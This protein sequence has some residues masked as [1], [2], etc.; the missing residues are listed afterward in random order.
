[1]NYIST[2]L[3]QRMSGYQRAPF[4]GVFRHVLFVE[5]IF[6][7]NRCGRA[8]TPS[9]VFHVSFAKMLCLCSPITG[10]RQ[11][12]LPGNIQGAQ[13]NLDFRSTRDTFLVH[14]CLKHCMGY[15]YTRTY[16]LCIRNPN[17]SGH[18]SFYLLKPAPLSGKPMRMRISL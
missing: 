14:V 5:G 15:S 7:S 1:M 12:G 8:S 16:L 11:P 9:R 2:K 17:L 6:Y 3:L 4:A 13:I 10:Q 18:L